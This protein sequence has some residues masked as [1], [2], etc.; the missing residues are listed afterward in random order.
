MDYTNNLQKKEK[1]FSNYFMFFLFLILFVM[2]I[3][4]IEA[5]KAF[6]LLSSVDRILS[7]I[8][9]FANSFIKFE[10]YVHSLPRRPHPSLT[11]N[12]SFNVVVVANPSNDVANSACTL[13]LRCTDCVYLLH[14]QPY[15][16]AT[17]PN[18]IFIL[19]V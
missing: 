8:I 7:S 4:L 5:I 9:L 17:V 12:L 18:V 1:L 14:F 3:F 11:E 16:D 15:K 6:S 2:S 19:S 10:S 13:W